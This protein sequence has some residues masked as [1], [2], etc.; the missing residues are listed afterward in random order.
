[1]NPTHK[2]LSEFFAENGDAVMYLPTPANRHERK[3]DEDRLAAVARR[4]DAH[5]VLTG[6]RAHHIEPQGEWIALVY[7]KAV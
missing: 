6:W 3:R 7:R 4:G 2:K 1:M 5:P